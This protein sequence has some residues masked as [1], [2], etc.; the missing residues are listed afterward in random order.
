MATLTGWAPHPDQ[1]KPLAPGSATVRLATHLGVTEE[2]AGE[3]PLAP[4]PALR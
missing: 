3:A 2:G 4:P 1:P